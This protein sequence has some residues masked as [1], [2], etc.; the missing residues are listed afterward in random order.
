MQMLPQGE[1]L[2]DYA[3][4]LIKN[5]KEKRRVD[6]LFFLPEAPVA[7]NI[8]AL[9][10]ISD[11]C[12]SD[13]LING[14]YGVF[15]SVKKCEYLQFK[16]CVQFNVKAVKQIIPPRI[17]KFKMK[18]GLKKYY[19]KR[20]VQTA[21]V[22]AFNCPDSNCAFKSA[23]VYF[24]MI[25]SKSKKY[26][27]TRQNRNTGEVNK[28]IRGAKLKKGKQWYGQYT[29]KTCKE[30]NGENV[31]LGFEFDF[32]PCGGVRGICYEQKFIRF[33]LRGGV[34][35]LQSDSLGQIINTQQILVHPNQ[36]SFNMPMNFYPYNLL[37]SLK[38]GKSIDIPYLENRF[39]KH[40]LRRVKLC[41]KRWLLF[42][43]FHRRSNLYRTYK[44]RKKDLLW[45]NR[46]FTSE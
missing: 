39:L 13:T 44:I 36:K 18:L 32:I 43:K 4:D 27:V 30:I 8:H 41:E 17:S 26:S 16:N 24:P 12:R 35:F 14:P 19:K 23:T 40:G 28:E 33:K 1:E 45:M 22:V 6:I 46:A 21:Y 3:A 5:K 9:V 29:F 10:N 7:E 42:M 11:S 2:D 37:F 20:R 25:E 38:T 34:K 15:Y 31:F